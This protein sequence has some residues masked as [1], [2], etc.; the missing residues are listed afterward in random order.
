MSGRLVVVTGTG[1]GI[2]K[3][4]L[5][6]ALLLAMGKKGLRAAGIKPVESGVDGS[7]TDADRLRAASSFHVKHRGL[8]LAAPIS[9]H[10]A[11]R[12]EGV[13]VDLDGLAREAR[14]CLADVDFLVLELPG[15]LFTPLTDDTLN[16]DWARRLS[17]DTVLLV[18]PDRLGVLHET[19]ATVRAA[20]AL[21]LRV[22]TIVLVAPEHADAS[23]G[24][25]APELRRFLPTRV[26]GTVARGA[27]DELARDPV[28]AATVATL[29]R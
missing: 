26:A 23:T 20:V 2:G 16:A 29:L 13:A 24:N 17:P 19:L 4:R 10:L 3:T 18:A 22:D 1:T 8:R 12:R 11:A 27:L 28:V 25:N 15:G 5:A 6:E 14:A 9:P 7:E 21:G